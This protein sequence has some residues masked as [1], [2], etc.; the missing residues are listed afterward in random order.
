MARRIGIVPL[1][2]CVGLYYAFATAQTNDATPLEGIELNKEL[3]R[4]RGV[5]DFAIW[6]PNL[7]RS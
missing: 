1:F 5:S 3:E 6:G 4:L 2:L 7:L